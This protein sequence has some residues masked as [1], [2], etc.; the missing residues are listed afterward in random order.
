MACLVMHNFYL[1]PH[2]KAKSGTDAVTLA[3]AA[4]A[5]LSI[6]HM[7]INTTQFFAVYEGDW[8]DFITIL[9]VT[10]SSLS[11]RGQSLPEST[12]TTYF[13]ESFLEVQENTPANIF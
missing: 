3:R 8:E 9:V 12:D 5:P 4:S 10:C 11:E 2:P 1:L 7:G 13:G 6:C